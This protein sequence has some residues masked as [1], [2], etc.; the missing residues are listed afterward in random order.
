[1]PVTCTG[2]A[3][4]DTSDTWEVSETC[5]V[6]EGWETSDT[7][8][9][10]LLPDS[11][12]DETGSTVPLLAVRE[13]VF[14]TSPWDAQAVT[15]QI[16]SSTARVTDRMPSHVFFDFLPSICFPPKRPKFPSF[17]QNTIFRLKLQTLFRY[18]SGFP[19][20]H[21]KG[22]CFSGGQTRKNKEKRKT[23][24]PC[25]VV[26]DYQQDF[27]AGPQGFPAARALEPILAER[28]RRYRAAG[29]AV[30]F[31]LDTG[32]SS[33]PLP[34]KTLGRTLYGR[35]E[36]EKRREDLCFVKDTFG[37]AALLDH[38]RRTSYASIE[39]A[40]VVSH[41]CVLANGILARTACPQTPIWVDPACV[42]SPERELE[43]AALNILQKIHIRMGT[44]LS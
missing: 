26:I 4:W 33:T 19:A 9:T 11:V 23:M 7:G 1:M 29:G 8:S 25:F 14:P 20:G 28:I 18:S 43:Q 6:S 36:Q 17:Q 40:G 32:G 12:D 24:Q 44:P 42:A 2:W 37:S 39:L 10:W 15:P 41:L 31:T 13:E 21:S 35:V 27:V 38:L 3:G 16:S 30:L 34:P 5:D 22:I